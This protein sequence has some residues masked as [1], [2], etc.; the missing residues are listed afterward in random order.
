M[1]QQLGWERRNSRPNVHSHPFTNLQAYEHNHMKQRYATS[2]VLVTSCLS[3]MA[4]PTL[5]AGAVT[6][7]PGE[8]VTFVVSEYSA[9]GSGGPSQI[10]DFA[11]LPSVGTNTVSYVS[12][13]QTGL[14][15]TFPNATVAQDET[16]GDYIFFRGSATGF[17]EDGFAVGGFT[18]TCSDRLT[19]VSYPLNYNN[20]FTDNSTCSVTDGTTTW[21]RTSSITGNA[22]G[23]GTVVLPWGS[24]SNVL[25]VHFLKNM[26]DNQYN[27]ASVYD[28]DTYGWYKPGVHAPILSVDRTTV[29]IFG[30]SFADSSATYADASAIGLEEAARHDIG[31]DLMPNPAIDQVEVIYG[32]GSGHALNIDVLDLTGKVVRTV[33]RRTF[34]AGVQ[35]ESLD[36]IGL[37][38]GA[39]LVRVTDDTGA[40]GMKRLVKL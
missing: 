30:F 6:P 40:T 17:E 31:V 2:L 32:L 5:G 22:D 1:E 3:A 33:A 36:I 13:A 28:N 35:R 25:R 16:G 24:V 4:Q 7:I 34:G 11:S 18:G 37:P 14:G 8:Q 9:P 39:Y 27:P 20:N 21:A 23:W 12:L 26:V 38:A 15:G 29:S 19:Y 10:W